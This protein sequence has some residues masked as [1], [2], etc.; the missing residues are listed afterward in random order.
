MKYGNPA[1]AAANV[2]FD[3]ILTHANEQDG[4]RESERVKSEHTIRREGGASML[5]GEMLMQ[6]LFL[7]SMKVEIFSLSD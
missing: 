4:D 1:A 3:A 5:K 2:T 6:L 7:L